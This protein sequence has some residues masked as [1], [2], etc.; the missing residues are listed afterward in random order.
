VDVYAALM[1]V[2]LG[3]ALWLGYRKLP[4]LVTASVLAG[5]WLMRFYLA[6]EMYHDKLVRYWPRTT[7]VV[8]YCFL[9]LAVFGVK[10]AA[11][12]IQE[13]Y[14]ALVAIRG[15]LDT[16]GADGVTRSE[17]ETGSAA[18]LGEDGDETD[19]PLATRS[20]GRRAVIPSRTATTSVGAGLVAAAFAL[21]FFAGMAGSADADKMMP[22]ND[23]S[24]GQLAW[25]AHFDNP[26]NLRLGVTLVNGK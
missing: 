3:V 14:E 5:A 20:R 23:G 9:I 21:T 10:A 18:A 16:Q 17:I 22:K 15:G 8:I 12:K 4:V 7:S 26:H 6:S 1:V 19:R 24:P 13:R 11:E 25:S 2:V